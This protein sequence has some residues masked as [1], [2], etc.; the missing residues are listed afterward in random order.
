VTV[1][2]SVWEGATFTLVHLTD[3]HITAEEHLRARGVETASR[4]RAVVES[5]NRLWPEP[6]LA[7]ITG[8]FSVGGSAT[9]FRRAA[10]LLTPLR[11]PVCAAL[12]NHD[13]PETFRAVMAP[14][15]F[16]G[17]G[18]PCQALI[19][20][21]WRI[22][23]LNSK[24]EGVK[25]GFLGPDQRRRVQG[26]LERHPRLPTLLFTHHH[27]VPLGLPWVD[28]DNM[29]DWHEFLT[30]LRDAGDVR[31][32]FSGHAH[33]ARHHSWGGIPFFVTPS[34]G[35]QFARDIREVRVEPSDPPAYR[36]IRVV[37]DLFTT[38]IRP[39]PPP[40]ETAD[41]AN[42]DSIAAGEK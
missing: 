36:L 10:E 33:Q 28:R 4:L 23:L 5:V 14:L 35:Y 15:G 26:E 39:V 2:P 40:C 13:D 3:L 42:P 16:A 41:A 1:I 29:R 24:W 20:Q 30:L 11:I 19:V 12:G 37:G 9:G 25:E 34:T 38:E 17:G 21:G 31:A 18:E 27:I 22:L 32:V 7:I 8:D 6:A